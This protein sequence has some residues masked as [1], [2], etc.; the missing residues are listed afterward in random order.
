MLILTISLFQPKQNLSRIKQLMVEVNP[1]HL[2][3][4]IINTDK[5]ST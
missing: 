3:K 1:K 2:N 5:L 4:M